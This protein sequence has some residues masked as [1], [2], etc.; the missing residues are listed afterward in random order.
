MAGYVPA[1]VFPWR[2]CR[3]PAASWEQGSAGLLR[4]RNVPAN[5]KQQRGL[6]AALGPAEMPALSLPAPTVSEGWGRRR[7]LPPSNLQAP[8]PLGAAFGAM[9]R[10]RGAQVV[11]ATPAQSAT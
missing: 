1:G 10:G 11:K 5:N 2:G 4:A 8:P 6:P 9:L 7:S 3:C